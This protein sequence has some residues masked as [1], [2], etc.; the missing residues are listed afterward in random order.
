MKRLRD[1]LHARLR[2]GAFLL[3]CLPLG[4]CDWLGEDTV[5][6]AAVA[7]AHPLATRAGMQILSSGGNA[8]DAA[9]AVTAV[10]AVVGP[11]GSGLGGGGFWLLHRASDG[12]QVM[13]DG[14]ERAP[15]A[16][17]RDMYLDDSGD[18]VDGLSINSALA[19]AIPG[20]PAAMVHIAERYGTLP[21]SDTLAPAIRIAREGFETNAQYNRL[22]QLRLADIQ[23]DPETARLF[24][25]DDEIPRPGYLIRQPELASTLEAIALHGRSGFYHGEVAEK[26]V[27]GV[28]RAGGI[29]SLADLENYR[30]V[31][32]TPQSGTYNGMRVVSA[33]LPS[34]GGVVLLTMLNILAGFPLDSLDQATRT[35]V[36]IE[37]MRRAYRD[38][39]EHLGDPDFHTAPVAELISTAHADRL[40]ET[41]RLDRATPYPVANSEAAV[42]EGMNTTHFSILDTEGNRVAATL[43]VNYP[44]G[45]CFT[46][47]GTGVLLNN[48]MDDFSAKPG[49]PNA[50]GL[51]G[52]EANAIAPGKRP[53]S[54]MSPTFVESEEGIAILG[55]PGGS[56][57]I[58]MVLLGILDLE[59]GGLPESWVSRPRFHH[60]YLPDVVQYES[61]AFDV[62]L[63][64]TLQGMGHTL[65]ELD[66]TYGNM[67][68]ILHDRKTGKVYA[69]SDP[70]GIGMSAVSLAD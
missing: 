70:R 47:P 58:T 41:I 40:R 30:V 26:L 15:L 64:D 65:K 1:I 20:E 21:I 28:R 39:A 48:E 53:L 55:T 54:S 35:H 12:L 49:V 14:R 6:P 24:L 45:A 11:H 51:V 22:A 10:L 36:I 69:A 33:S 27:E 2:I 32:R 23:N 29:W 46:P 68:A 4:G 44:F 43:S 38:R 57:I 52:A 17:T 19:A 7:S 8:F 18:V 42:A 61:D 50:Y 3:L 37:A 5:T 63:A 67:Q 62:D 16:A 66:S 31:E 25:Q 59:E 56:R 60:Q 9:V 34:S 13:I